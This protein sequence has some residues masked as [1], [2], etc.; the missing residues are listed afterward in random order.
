VVGDAAKTRQFL[1]SLIKSYYPDMRMVIGQL[2]TACVGGRL[3][4]DETVV[5][6]REVIENNI[7]QFMDALKAAATPLEMRKTYN[8]EVL[9]FGGNGNLARLCT[10]Y[11]LAEA[12]FSHIVDKF[13]APVEDLMELVDRLY[14]IEHSVDA[15]TQLFGF[16]LKV[17]TLV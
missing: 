1:G 10:P 7:S 16:L 12:V 9:R 14:K 8:N 13:N 15:E 2:Q 3:N 11:G 6:D 17:K 4:V 5:D